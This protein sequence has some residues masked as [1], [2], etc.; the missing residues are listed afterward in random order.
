MENRLLGSLVPS[1]RFLH[2]I[3]ARPYPWYISIFIFITKFYDEATFKRS[4]L[5]EKNYEYSMTFSPLLVSLFNDLGHSCS[6]Y[7]VVLAGFYDKLI[8]IIIIT[9]II[10]IIIKIPLFCCAQTKVMK[11]LCNLSKTLLFR[12]IFL[13]WIKVLNLSLS[14][15]ITASIALI[16]ACGEEHHAK[17]SLVDKSDVRRWSFMST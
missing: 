16:L 5:D 17:G 13:Q 4:G 11:S 3:T 9:I 7:I 6:I 2:Y 15:S 12:H 10:I 14:A 8:I 1:Q